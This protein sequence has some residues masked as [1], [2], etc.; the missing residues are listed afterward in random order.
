MTKRSSGLAGAFVLL[1]VAVGAW[2]CS[3][4]ETPEPSDGTGGTSGGSGS[5]GGTAATGGGTA[6]SGGGTAGSGGGTAGSGGTPGTGGGSGDCVVQGRQ[7][8]RLS[9]R[10][11]VA[12]SRRMG[13]ARRSARCARPWPAVWPTPAGAAASAPIPTATA[14]GRGA[15][16]RVIS[17]CRPST[18][19]R[20]AH[21]Y[22]ASRPTRSRALAKAPFATT[23][24]AARRVP[25][26][27]TTRAR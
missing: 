8:S 3:S 26:G 22:A 18:C 17:R 20:R 4:A 12:A 2:S 1:A 9:R 14:W 25:A 7:S 11:S 19:V 13:R 27:P 23:R 10:W 24:R 15:A 21:R 16:C 6:G 5:G